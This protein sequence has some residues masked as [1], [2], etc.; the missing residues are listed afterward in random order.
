MNTSTSLPNKKSADPFSVY[1]DFLE[2][3]LHLCLIYQANLKPK[4]EYVNPPDNSLHILLQIIKGGVK[5]RC[6]E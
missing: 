4:Q 1:L 6:H 3:S 2:P 5:I